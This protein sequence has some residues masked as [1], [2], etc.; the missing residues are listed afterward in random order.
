MPQDLVKNYD[1]D[2][3]KLP[4]VQAQGI[5]LGF[6]SKRKKHFIDLLGDNSNPEFKLDANGLYYEFDEPMFVTAITV[7]AA[8][9]DGIRLKYE[10]KDFATREFKRISDNFIEEHDD[11]SRCTI[12]QFITGFKVSANRIGFF[13]SSEKVSK[14]QVDL[15]S[16]KDLLDLPD[17]YDQ[18]LILQGKLTSD[19][20]KAVAAVET[21]RLELESKITAHNDDVTKS[22]LALKR[23]KTAHENEISLV[24]EKFAAQEDELKALNASVSKRE[25]D[26]KNLEEGNRALTEAKA[27]LESQLRDLQANS[28]N[29]SALIDE[30]ES[31]L[32]LKSHQIS[33][34]NDRLQELHNDVSLF[35]DDVAGFAAQTQSQNTKYL[36]ILGCCLLVSAGLAYIS[37]QSTIEV[38]NTF[39]AMPQLGVLN[40]LGIK[41]FLLIFMGFAFAFLYKLAKPFMD[42]IITNNRKRLKMSEVS[43]LAR[44]TSDSALYGSDVSQEDKIKIKMATRMTLMREVLSGVYDSRSLTKPVFQLQD[45]AIVERDATPTKSLSNSKTEPKVKKSEPE[46]TA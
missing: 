22:K 2:L 39:K 40:L 37:I 14:I 11:L 15:V 3:A 23:E 43:I 36:W 31:N 8:Q 34:L 12:N 26:K 24:K 19:T 45:T 9:E 32:T 29:L 6:F 18:Y 38:F 46:P 5:Q 7:G 4:I 25:I 1:A 20:K 21:Q 30:R 28:Q 35:A 10:V 33:Q 13:S 41:A 16:T 42:E 17:I 44:D 27:S